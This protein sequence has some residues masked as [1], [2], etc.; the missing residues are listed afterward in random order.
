MLFSLNDIGRMAHSFLE[1]FSQKGIF[2]TPKVDTYLGEKIPAL[3]TA[4][5]IEFSLGD[6]NQ[7]TKTYRIEYITHPDFYTPLT[8]RI[9]PDLNYSMIIL[10]AEEIINGYTPFVTDI[11]GNI[12][13]DKRIPSSDLEDALREIEL[14]RKLSSR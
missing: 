12:I 4:N 1:V 10:K 13:Q 14:L 9:N 8:L 6:S 11:F 3:P 7:G 2:S 5:Y